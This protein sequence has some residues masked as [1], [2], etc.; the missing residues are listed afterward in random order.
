MTCF[1]C[2]H[3]TLSGS[4]NCRRGN[5]IR[6]ARKTLTPVGSAGIS[7]RVDESSNVMKLAE[8]CIIAVTALDLNTSCAQASEYEMGDSHAAVARD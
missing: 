5:R 7:P 3:V 4:R 8:L 1:L 2:I 6:T